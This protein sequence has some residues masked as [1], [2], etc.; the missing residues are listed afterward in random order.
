MRN[1]ISGKRV[2]HYTRRRAYILLTA[3]FLIG[4][5]LL[6]T[7][8][9]MQVFSHAYFSDMVADQI[10]TGSPL[11][12]ERGNIYDANGN[13]L[14]TNITVWRIYL[15]PVDIREASEERGIDYAAVIADGLSSILGVDRDLILRRARQSKTLD[16]TVK[17]NVGSEEYRAVLRFISE[18]GLD[19]MV[20]A[21]ASV[22]R[23]Y[24]G[25]SF[26]AHVL[27]F[28]GSDLQGLFGLEYQYDEILS[29]T[30]G[31]Y[32]H[33]KDATGKELKNVYLSYK[34]A[35][36]GASIVTTIDSYIQSKLEYTVQEIEKTFDVQNRVT[37]VVMNVKSGAI[38]GMAT[39]SPFDC[40]D[41]YTLDPLSQARLDGSGYT[42]GSEDYKKLKNELLY[43]MWRNK[44][45]SELYEPG[46]TFKIMT[47][48]MALDL[49][50]VSPSDKFSCSGSLRIGGYNISCH[51]HGGHGSGF[52]FAYGLQQS[53][54]PTLMQ[55]GARIGSEQFYNFFEKFGYFEKTGVDLPSE[56]TAL[57]HKKD[58]IGTT[59][60]ATAS[61][62]QRFK[63]S[64]LQQ[65]TA[66]AAVANGGYLVTPY[67]VQSVIDASGAVISE[68]K[69][70]IKRQVISSAA[71]STVSEI[72]E[73]GVSGDGGARNAYVAGYKV[74]AKTG[75]SQKFDI[76]DENGN[77]YL[78]IGSCV[79][80]APSDDTEIAMIIVVDEPTTAKY[81]AV[82]AAPYISAALTSIL[83]YLEVKATEKDQIKTETVGDYTT[84]T[85][86][87]AKTALRSSALSFRIIGN[88]ER[89]VS[90]YPAAGSVLDSSI[91]TLILY[92]DGAVSE[93]VTV[94]NLIGMS[95]PEANAALLSRGLNI[96]ITGIR[97][98][99]HGRGALV[100]MQ[101][102]A[103]GESLPIGSIVRI[104]VIF[105]DDAD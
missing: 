78:R 69:T 47:A 99:R 67:L 12:A 60:L 22:T 55:V 36:P 27:G 52:S 48:A 104:T 87:Q 96:S 45:T 29:G 65:L 74:A 9:R 89:I 103:P 43:T 23:Y 18:K 100:T 19:S 30:D 95:M 24:P 46:S 51:K 28:T 1:E 84:L 86:G 3:F 10:T 39:S 81:G 62:G 56:V 71:A 31:S 32:L 77:S 59:E 102:V 58:A 50:V 90:Q 98:D 21:E 76:L 35:I 82:V 54:N 70:E 64:I 14:A 49:G 93:T 80:F 88:G 92:T 44:A 17:K 33:A 91:G 79:A 15:S 57:F 63:V 83:P 53:C 94:P 73:A 66:V 7:V 8:F 61:F 26:A 105:P 85:V 101:S 20:H 37:A 97:D 72:L 25:G 38:L 41:P 42:L 11:K 2:F 4:A 5:Y 34:E 16:Q 40:N 6:L 75:T 13:L 68:H